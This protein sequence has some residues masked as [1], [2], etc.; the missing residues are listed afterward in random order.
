MAE[1]K[2]SEAQVEWLRRIARTG[3]WP[4][5]PFLRDS[6]NA[7]PLMR[8]GLVEAIDPPAFP[9]RAKGLPYV[10]ITPAGRRALQGA[11]NG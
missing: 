6:E 9:G 1:T 5:T 2:L 10:I 3:T 11:G 4:D 8:L 7:A